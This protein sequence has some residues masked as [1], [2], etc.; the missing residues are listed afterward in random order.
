MGVQKI[1]NTL[2]SAYNKIILISD[3]STEQQE[4]IGSIHEKVSKSWESILHKVTHNQSTL[5]IDG[6]TLVGAPIKFVIQCCSESIIASEI[7]REL[8]QETKSVDSLGTYLMDVLA[9]GIN[10]SKNRDSY[11]HELKKYPNLYD[12]IKCFMVLNHPLFVIEHFDEFEIKE[13][14]F[15][16]GCAIKLAE[17]HPMEVLTNF[18][19]FEI[20]EEYQEY[21]AI[22][23]ANLD[24]D[25]FEEKFMNSAISADKFEEIAISLSQ[26]KQHVIAKFFDKLDIS[27]ELLIELAKKIALENP[28]A[29]STY[30]DNFQIPEEYLNEFSLFLMEKSPLLLAKH[31]NRFKIPKDK[32]LEFAQAISKKYAYYL[33]KHLHLYDIPIAKHLDYATLFVKRKPMGLCRFLENFQLPEDQVLKLAGQLTKRK[34]IGLAKYFAK[35]KV[36][37]EKH[38]D[39]L[40]HIAKNNPQAA[41]KYFH[42]FKIPQSE[43]YRFAT[44]FA[45]KASCDLAESIEHFVLTSE[46]R[47]KLMKVVMKRDV[48]ALAEHFEKFQVED[49]DLSLECARV[50][51]KASSELLIETF[52]KFHIPVQFHFEFAETLARKYQLSKPLNFDLFTL[53]GDEKFKL[54]KLLSDDVRC[55][56]WTQEKKK[57]VIT[58]SQY[59]DSFDLSLDQHMELV[60][61]LLKR[62]EEYRTKVVSYVITYIRN[63]NLPRDKHVD[64]VDKLFDVSSY[65]LLD[66]IDRFE[67]SL[68]KRIEISQKYLD[69]EEYFTFASR[70]K[71]FKLPIEV[72][73][74]YAFIIAHACPLSTMNAIYLFDLP[75]EDHIVIAEIVSRH[76]GEGSLLSHLKNLDLPYKEGG[77]KWLAIH[78]DYLDLPLDLRFT[79]FEKVLHHDPAEAAR[80][81]PKFR[82]PV[83]S[84]FRYALELAKKAPVEMACYFKNFHLNVEQRIECAKIIARENPHY[85]ACYLEVFNLPKEAHVS[86]AKILAQVDPAALFERRLLQILKGIDDDV[87][88]ELKRIS[89]ACCPEKLALVLHEFKEED[90]KILL[91]CYR[92]LIRNNDTNHYQTEIYKKQLFY[93]LLHL[94]NIVRY[95]RS[96]DYGVLKG[97]IESVYYEIWMNDIQDGYSGFINLFSK[98][99]TP[100]F[101][102][103]FLNDIIS[104][105]KEH[106]TVELMKWLLFLYVLVD[107]YQIDESRI[108]IRAL[109]VIS[110]LRNPVHR[111]VMTRILIEEIA[112]SEEYFARLTTEIEMQ[113]DY[114][115]YFEVLFQA[116]EAQGVDLKVVK[117]Y[118]R[119]GQK[120][121]PPNTHFRK[122]VTRKFNRSENR[123]L[124]I[125]V[126][127]SLYE[128]TISPEI[129]SGVLSYLASL[130]DS[131]QL[132]EDLTYLNLLIGFKQ[133]QR[134]IELFK[135]QKGQIPKG[136]LFKMIKELTKQELELDEEETV[137]FI[138]IFFGSRMPEAVGIYLMKIKDL[139]SE[140]K[141]A[142]MTAFQRYIQDV[143]NGR[144]KE[145]RYLL[146]QSEHFKAVFEGRD[147]LLVKW[148][149]NYVE[150]HPTKLESNPHKKE[151][152][153][154][155]REFLLDQFEHHHLERKQFPLLYKDLKGKAV[156]FDDEMN[157]SQE[158]QFQC[159]KLLKADKNEVLELILIVRGLLM[160]LSPSS[161][162]FE[163]LQTLTR[164]FS[165]TKNSDILLTVVE[166]DDPIDLLLCGTEVQDSC[167]R[168]AG[169]AVHNKALL[170]YVI[171]G[172]NK[173]IA[174]KRRDGSLYARVIFRILLDETTKKPVLFLERTYPKNLPDVHVKRILQYAIKRAKSLGLSLAAKQ[175]GKGEAYPNKLVSKGSQAP[176]EY[177]D[178]S[179]RLHNNEGEYVISHAHY[180]WNAAE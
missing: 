79:Y 35:F 177:C 121:R 59:C 16:F 161:E 89:L 152:E 75:Q 38:L 149:E 55:S 82:L 115:V 72:R 11:L 51:L 29:F 170:G 42:H 104:E 90:P 178:A 117:P 105:P 45:E 145:N 160:K 57:K 12:Q 77:L 155:M 126:L 169:H 173:V 1:F 33:A 24:P 9:A 70:I 106:V 135:A 26:Q 123:I 36:A 162:F 84:H 37:P 30:I 118:M 125:E 179:D 128:S 109:K 52:D 18:E 91:K 60:K 148:K 17:E 81:F 63:L 48:K 71:K 180:L 46:E 111:I 174:L 62:E 176:F 86:L 140:E 67:L 103:T 164:V 144:F 166:T 119:P 83:E 10:G 134:L 28:E 50:L 146:D 150:S 32:H 94:E 88:Q 47:Q 78:F 131:N 113:K 31:F 120:K 85:F 108:P 5:D 34:P 68:E 99:G 41:A 116:L 147:D 22:L 14:N 142:L 76:E 139:R 159:L 132:I 154:D 96:S 137:R 133:E 39:I 138:D 73:R 23:A 4:Q 98:K 65:K 6:S 3:V 143:C 136:T 61:I 8:N 141:E 69:N 175:I 158:F 40:K 157:L 151:K 92:T 43:H 130:P 56:F 127:S 171:D 54:A 153:F 124:L 163:D 112:N 107:Y 27:D 95:N 110:K 156:E 49:R 114:S 122:K 2:E 74:K 13:I 80:H 53:N 100:A 20:P 97:K 165:E 7:L 167:Q 102:Y 129:K 19:R 93:P 168:V 64:F 87:V 172:K 66:V 58:F 101:Y 44:L 21:F 25:I 15:R